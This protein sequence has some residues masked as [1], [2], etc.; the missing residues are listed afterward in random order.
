[1]A[2]VLATNEHDWFARDTYNNLGLIPAV[3][4]KL[5]PTALPYPTVLQ[6]EV[7]HDMYGRETGCKPQDV[8]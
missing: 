2:I 7:R 1:M 3:P 6:D 5:D 8:Y 4:M